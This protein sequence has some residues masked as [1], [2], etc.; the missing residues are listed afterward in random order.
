MQD[1]FSN[2]DRVPQSKLFAYI[3]ELLRENKELKEKIKE[4]ER[5]A[6]ISE[7]GNGRINVKYK[8]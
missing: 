1:I 5:S 4:L 6:N 2:G 7:D 8:N 3:Q